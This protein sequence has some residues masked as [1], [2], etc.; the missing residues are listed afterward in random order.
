MSIRKSMPSV[1]VPASR[2]LLPRKSPMRLGLPRQSL[3]VGF[4]GKELAAVEI[5]DSFGQ[6]SVLQFMR[7]EGNVAFDA[8]RFRFTPPAGADVVEQ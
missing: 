7:F 8:E 6:R 4:R 1:H 5:V 3:R 2:S